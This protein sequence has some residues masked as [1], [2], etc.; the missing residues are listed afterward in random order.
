MGECP[1]GTDDNVGDGDKNMEKETSRRD[2][3]KRIIACN[4]SGLGSVG[5][6]KLNLYYTAERIGQPDHQ[7][8]ALGG[9]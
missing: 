9:E 7:V 6:E 5:S 8:V 3:R 2:E 4:K 1:A